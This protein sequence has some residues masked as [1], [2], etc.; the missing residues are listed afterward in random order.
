MSSNP[1]LLT[2][3]QLDTTTARYPRVFVRWAFVTGGAAVLALSVDLLATRFGQIA[4]LPRVFQP[5]GQTNQWLNI[6]LRTWPLRF[7]ACCAAGLLVLSAAIT[8]ARQGRAITAGVRWLFWLAVGLLAV[9]AVLDCV[10]GMALFMYQSPKAG[11]VE[12]VLNTLLGVSKALLPMVLLS[13]AASS[14]FHARPSQTRRLVGTLLACWGTVAVA[15]LITQL[16]QW[17]LG[18]PPVWAQYVTNSKT[19]SPME[20]SAMS[21]LRVMWPFI[22]FVLGILS[23]TAGV[24]ERWG[25]AGLQALFR[26][27][28]V[29]WVMPV[30]LTSLALAIYAGHGHSSWAAVCSSLLNGCFESLICLFAW[31]S[32]RSDSLEL[33]AS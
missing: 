11:P 20:R 6:L 24:A 5:G 21:T 28:A 17:A 14:Q 27:I 2:Y 16:V 31:S 29:I 10:S 1:Q 30:V 32:V 25:A 7:A 22:Q 19:W 8:T 23:L 12:M 3:A 18:R 33:P 26:T 13:R 4:S 15:M 9:C